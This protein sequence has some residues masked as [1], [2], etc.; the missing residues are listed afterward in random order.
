MTLPL[1]LIIPQV[2]NFQGEEA[3]I[4][5]VSLVRS[6]KTG[7]VGFLKTTNRINVLLRYALS[8]PNAEAKVGQSMECTLLAIRNARKAAKCGMT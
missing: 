7:A 3:L 1:F 4:I 5:V 6:N 2:D 8:P